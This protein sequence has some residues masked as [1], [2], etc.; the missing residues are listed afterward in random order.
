MIRVLGPKNIEMITSPDGNQ[1]WLSRCR[2]AGFTGE[3][4]GY[5]EGKACDPPEL[6]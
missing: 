5:P 4:F 3:H 1:W 6:L 2:S